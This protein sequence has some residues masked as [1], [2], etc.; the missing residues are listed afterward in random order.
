MLT[1]ILLA[2]S[3]AAAPAPRTLRV[4]W[5]HTGNATEERFSVDRIVLEPL[6]FPGRPDRAIDETNLG[7]YLFE[8][9]DV[10]TNRLLYSRGFASIYGEWELTAE[11][12]QVNRT[13]SESFRFPAPASPVQV[14][15]KKR[16][17]ANV[18]REVWSFVVD[19]KDKFISD[20]PPPSPGPVTAIQKSGAPEEKFDLL[21]VGDGYTEKE[22]G[23]FEKD[24]RRLVE[25]LFRQS[26][27]QERRRDFNVWAIAPATA[28]S[29]ISRPLTGVHRRSLATYDAFGSERYVLSFEN[30]ALR[31]YASHAPYDALAIV[32]NGNTY[33]GGGIFNLYTT[34]A[35]DSKWSEYV[36]VHELGH[37]LAALA[38]EY[39]TS[40][41]AYLPVEGRPEPWEANITADGT[42]PKWKDLVAP[43][44]PLPTPWPKDAFVKSAVAFQDQR[45]K[46]RAENGPESAM[47]AL[48]LA[49]KQEE[50]ALLS[51]AGHAHAVGAFE[52][53]NYEATGFFRP[54]V[55][56][57]M[58][59]RNDVPFCRVC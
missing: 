54:Q 11:A 8:V 47:D 30:R 39:F 59:S 41:T 37:S 14:V 35:A 13:F 45:K 48:F 15:L 42:N 12:Q 9:R 57:V 55:D 29:G 51:K 36:F 20:A 17:P 50:T 27:F 21:L 38:D 52:G 46:I 49:Q 22:R 25:A 23:K 34:V 10:G 53:A 5:F 56:C 33:G 40:D 26:P 4:D 16:G 28:Q 18:F 31:D 7:K 1:T 44:T 24:A 58:F 19:P 6:P 43:G 2:A 3:L 32:V